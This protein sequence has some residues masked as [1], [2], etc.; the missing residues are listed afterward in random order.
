MLTRVSTHR[1]LFKGKVIDTNEKNRLA[2]ITYNEKKQKFFS[3]NEQ[4][5]NL[6]VALQLRASTYA[7][8]F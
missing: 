8:C 3:Y 7:D 1:L 6:L 2:K 5:R 4:F